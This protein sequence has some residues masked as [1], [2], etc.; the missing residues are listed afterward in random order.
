MTRYIPAVAWYPV[1]SN[2]SK[3]SLVGEY[4][5]PTAKKG[6]SDAP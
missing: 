4:L 5:A 1:V 6:M 3:V 2:P